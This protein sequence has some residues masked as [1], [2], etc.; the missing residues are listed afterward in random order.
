MPTSVSVSRPIR[1]PD[2][3][4]ERLDIGCKLFL[5]ILA[6]ASFP[7]KTTLFDGIS[8]RLWPFLA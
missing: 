8:A 7:A 1:V 6:H 4:G 5:P 2:H 3:L